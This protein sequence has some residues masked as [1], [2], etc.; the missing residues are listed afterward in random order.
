M[1]IARSTAVVIDTFLFNIFVKI[2]IMLQV[3]M[4]TD[5]N[6]QAQRSKIAKTDCL[7]TAQALS[8]FNK[9][10]KRLAGPEAVIQIRTEDMLQTLALE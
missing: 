8:T 10:Q 4:H 3:C 7:H 5:Y 2:L 9:S 1:V 6:F